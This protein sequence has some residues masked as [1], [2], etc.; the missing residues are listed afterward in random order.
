MQKWKCY[1]C[2]LIYLI[3]VL[4]DF[5]KILSWKELNRGYAT[6][7]DIILMKLLSY[8]RKLKYR[9]CTFWRCVKDM[10]MPQPQIIGTEYFV[11]G[12]RQTS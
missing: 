4:I 7:T 3:T 2:S 12:K 1:H 10:E 8:F 6:V 5:K 9:A 11:V